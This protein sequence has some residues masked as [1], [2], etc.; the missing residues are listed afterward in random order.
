MNRINRGQ[1]KFNTK[2]LEVQMPKVIGGSKS[3]T[4]DELVSERNYIQRSQRRGKVKQK[5]KRRDPRHFSSLAWRRCRLACVP[6]T[7]VPWSCFY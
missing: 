4:E 5:A 7:G 6:G 1:K 2:E 3:R